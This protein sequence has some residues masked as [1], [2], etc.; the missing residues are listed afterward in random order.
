LT[1]ADS[2]LERERAYHEKLYSGFA[3]THFARPAV[4][5][6]REHLA[7]RILHLAGAG[8]SSRVLSLGCGLGD[9]E[10]LLAPHVGEL[11]GFDLSPSAVRQA[12]VDAERLN[13]RNVTFIEGTEP[14][15]GDRFDVII[16]IF[17][18]H[19]LPDEIL[20][21]LP[22]R[23]RAMFNPGGVFYSLDPSVRRLSGAI[24]RR[25]IPNMVKKYQTPD[26]RELDPRAT[27]E[28][29]REAGFLVRLEMYDF[30]STPFAG[31]IPGWR[32]GYRA[33]RAADDVLMRVPALKR[34]GSN[35]EIVA[36]RP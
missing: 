6:F 11:V 25:L 34:A 26:E 31:L 12:R 1:P 9:T 33:V 30:G 4:R 18:L 35:F 22:D 24:G 7:K 10:L 5:A 23:L 29:F 19:H 14:K 28:L 21:A 15:D 17:L 2:V 27:A 32:L 13:L 36:T 16:A 20:L 8:R 3:Q